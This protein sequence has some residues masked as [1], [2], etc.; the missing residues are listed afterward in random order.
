M[1]KKRIDVAV[2]VV[3]AGHK[4]LVGQRLVQDSYYQK[5]EFPGG[6]LDSG[7]QPLNALSRELKEELG[8]DVISARPLITLEHD[9]PD[10]QVRLFV[11]VV[12]KFHG[13]P[14]GAEGQAVKWVTPQECHRLDFLAA[15]TPIVHA[16]QLPSV[17][18]ITDIRQYGLDKTLSVVKSIDETYNSQFILQLREHNLSTKQCNEYLAEFRS[19]TNSAFI[20]LNGEPQL[21]LNAGFD[22]VQLNRQ[23]SK[24]YTKREQLP[25]FWVG[26][27][28]HNA[29]ELNHSNQMA[30]FALLSPVNTT[31]SHP[32]ISSDLTLGWQG[33]SELSRQSALPCYALGGVGENDIE[34]SWQHGAQGVAGISNF[35]N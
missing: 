35:W 10:R 13:E 12:T 5:W 19:V 4:V 33:F 27:S 17:Q 16:I 1:N 11:F 15:N 23:R 6:K 21:A 14:V 3:K 2:G 7:E 31:N 20:F 26:V 34:A 25:D 29:Q 24:V 32:E 8:I 30:D 22:G 9:Y 18:L 28:C